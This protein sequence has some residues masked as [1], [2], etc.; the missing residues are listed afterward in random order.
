MSVVITPPDP[1]RG[2]E[3]LPESS[4]D[5]YEWEGELLPVVCIMDCASR[6]VV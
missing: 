1:P 3:N 5:N 4:I 6:F 2:R